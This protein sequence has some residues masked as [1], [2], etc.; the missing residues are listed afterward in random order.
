MAVAGRPFDGLDVATIEV[1]DGDDDACRLHCRWRGSLFA[2]PDAA[3]LPQRRRRRRRVPSRSSHRLDIA[4][5]IGRARPDGDGSASSP[6][7]SITT[8]TLSGGRAG[9]RR[10]GHSTSVT[11]SDWRSSMRPP[12]S[13]SEASASRYRSMWKSGRRPRYSAMRM[14]GRRGDSRSRR[15]PRRRLSRGAS[16]PLRAHPTGRRGRPARGCRERPAE[17]CRRVRVR[18]A[19]V[20]VRARPREA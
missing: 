12:A 15:G 7:P 20:D 9:P 14:K 6:V 1:A 3:G 16:C 17:R 4:A 8:S 19:H 5:Q 11:P 10:S 18:R 2:R 13:A